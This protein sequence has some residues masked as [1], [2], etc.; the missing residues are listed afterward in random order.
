MTLDEKFS[1]IWGPLP[2]EQDSPPTGQCCTSVPTEAASKEGIAQGLPRVD[3]LSRKEDGIF[4]QEVK[5]EALLLERGDPSVPTSCQK[6]REASHL[7]AYNA[8]TEHIRM[9]T[10]LSCLKEGRTEKLDLIS[11]AESH[12]AYKKRYHIYGIQQ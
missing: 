9:D 6:S 7:F 1:P 11:G 4:H 5:K 8:T 12:V 3:T 2:A 10:T